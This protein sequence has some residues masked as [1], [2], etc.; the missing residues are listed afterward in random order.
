M[1]AITKVAE[2]IEKAERLFDVSQDG[3]G[4]EKEI[5]FGLAQ[6][7]YAWAQNEVNSK[8]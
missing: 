5:K 8:L 7:V 3:V 6:V 2:E 4:D 1:E